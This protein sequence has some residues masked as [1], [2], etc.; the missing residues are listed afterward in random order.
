MFTSVWQ[1]SIRLLSST[2]ALSVSMLVQSRKPAYLSIVLW[3]V[4]C[5]FTRGSPALQ[6]IKELKNTRSESTAISLKGEAASNHW[7]HSKESCKSF[8][9][10]WENGF[11]GVLLQFQITVRLTNTEE[12]V[13][14]EDGAGSYLN[15]ET[16][17]DREAEVEEEK[18]DEVH[19]RG[20]TT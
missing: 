17:T 7:L 18:E 19:A 20:K 1:S 13:I 6:Q 5:N 14:A 11:T 12:R 15:D 2:I 10:W 8:V 9:I 3:L 16:E 4:I